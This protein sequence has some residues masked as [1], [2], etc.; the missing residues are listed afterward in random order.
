M[1]FMTDRDARDW[2]SLQFRTIFAALL[3]ACLCAAA[4]RRLRPA[5][6]QGGS[7]RSL[8][9]EARESAGTGARLALAG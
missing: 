5:F 4:L 8:L 9:A 7:R 6:W 3:P 1:T 2:D